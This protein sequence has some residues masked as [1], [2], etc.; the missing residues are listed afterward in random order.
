MGRVISPPCPT[1]E[2]ASAYLF[3]KP[4]EINRMG[5][6]INV[7]LYNNA[8]QKYGRFVENLIILYRNLPD[9]H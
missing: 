3:V 2:V 9:S 5:Y 4:L 8:Y 1:C 6:E 7:K